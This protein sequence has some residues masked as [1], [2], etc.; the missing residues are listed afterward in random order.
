[1]PSS[2]FD[3]GNHRGR[4]VLPG[5]LRTRALEALHLDRIDRGGAARGPHIDADHLAPGGQPDPLRLRIPAD[6]SF[7]TMVR[8]RP[9]TVMTAFQ[10]SS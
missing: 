5:D 8:L 1:M 9:A 7:S 4:P 2:A 6:L 3:A 10:I